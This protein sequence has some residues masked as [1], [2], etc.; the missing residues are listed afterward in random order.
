MAMNVDIQFDL[1]PVVT[2]LGALAALERTGQNP[3]EYL[4]R[5]AV[6]DWGDLCEEDKTSNQRALQDGSRILS[7]YT[8][9]DGTKLWVITDAEIDEHHHRQATTFLLPEEY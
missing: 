4:Q 2:T 7:A 9:P 6:G 8:L 5:H 1:G 3:S